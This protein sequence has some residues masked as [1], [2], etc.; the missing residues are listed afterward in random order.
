MSE[1][2]SK[3]AVMTSGGDA[4]G[5][6]A[7]I[8]AV[9]RT[10]KFYGYDVY[11]INRGFSGL[12]DADIQELDARSVAGIIDRG[13]TF[14][15]SA[16]CKEMM[17][18]EGQ[19]KAGNICKAL[20]I[21]SLI[22]IGGD[23]SITGGLKLN[24]HGVNVIGIPGTIDLDLACSEYTIGFDTALNT[25]IEAIQKL[26][27][28]AGSH[29][30][31]SI[32]EVMGRNCGE[33]ALWSG[34]STGADI[35]LV[36]EIGPMPIEDIITRVIKQR[37]GGKMHNIIVV[38]EGIG[39]SEALAK[40]IEE[41][42]GIVARATILGHLQRGGCPTALDR[43]TASLMG[44]EAVKLINEGAQNRI[45]IMKNNKIDSIDIEEGLAMQG[46]SKIDQARY[47]AIR[48]LSV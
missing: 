43:Y 42:T 23:G 10:A 40:E 22:I 7:A 20:G 29:Q 32:V 37:A 5:M 21:K 45:V 14:L 24:K 19:E 46:Q 48:A 27:D 18:P 35:V 13:G 17:T 25:A 4:P 12:L 44:A 38:A 16:R 28:T 41:K 8:R 11:G 26:R 1:R 6:N 36:P 39:G 34:I 2:K 33:L 30:R 31:C 3:I 47:E 9:V 15:K